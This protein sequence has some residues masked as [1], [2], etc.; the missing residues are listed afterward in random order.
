MEFTR[1]NILTDTPGGKSMSSGGIILEGNQGGSGGDYVHP[2]G[3]LW[4]NK[5]T[6]RETLDGD[7]TSHGTIKCVD[8]NA[9]NISSI[10]LTS[11]NINAT[12][13][14]SVNGDFTD[15]NVFDNLTSYGADIDHATIRN[16]F[17]SGSAHF[18]ELI[19]DKLNSTNGSLILSPAH[20]EISKVEVDGN[21]ITCYFLASDGEKKI[22]NDFDV[23]D[24]VI[25][26]SFN[27]V[28][29]V[30]HDVDNKFIWKRCIA[31][32]TTQDGSEHWIK[33]YTTES[34]MGAN[35][36]HTDC[37][38]E[39]EVADVICTLGNWIKTDRQKAI[40]MTA[41]NS[42]WLD[43]GN[44]TADYNHSYEVTTY[45]SNNP[46]IRTAN[47][48]LAIDVG[49]L[50]NGHYV[51]PDNI[52]KPYVLSFID[53]E[54]IGWGQAFGNDGY[55]SNDP[56]CD[57]KIFNINQGATVEFK[58]RPHFDESIH[59]FDYEYRDNI[60]RYT[61]LPTYHWG[62]IDDGDT[63]GFSVFAMMGFMVWCVRTFK[64]VIEN[65]NRVGYYCTYK[66][67][68]CKGFDIVREIRLSNNTINS[69]YI[70]ESDNNASSDSLLNYLGGR[71]FKPA[72]SVRY[73]VYAGD[74]FGEPGGPAGIRCNALA[75]LSANPFI[76][77]SPDYTQAL[78]NFVIDLYSI[79]VKQNGLVLWDYNAN[80][81]LGEDMIVNG[82]FSKSGYWETTFDNDTNSPM[83]LGNAAEN[84]YM[85]SPY[86]KSIYDSSVVYGGNNSLKDKYLNSN[87][88]HFDDGI[89]IL[90]FDYYINNDNNISYYNENRSFNKSREKFHFQLSLCRSDFTQSHVRSDLEVYP[91]VSGLHK[92]KLIIGINVDTTGMSLPDNF[93]NINI[94]SGV[95]RDYLVGINTDNIGN[96]NELVID[97]VHLRKVNNST[98]GYVKHVDTWECYPGSYDLFIYTYPFL[99][100]YPYPFSC[101]QLVEKKYKGI[102]TNPIDAPAII[103]FDNINDFSL[104]G[105]HISVLSPRYNLISANSVNGLDDRISHSSSFQLLEDQINMTVTQ[106]E[107]DELNQTVINQGT[108]ISQ[109]A[110]AITLKADKTTVNT[111]SGEVSS[112]NSSIT[113]LSD[114][115]TLNSSAIT[116]LNSD[117]TQLSSEL[118]I[119]AGEISSLVSSVSS[120]DGEV[121]RLWSSITQLPDQISAYVYTE[122]DGDLTQTGIDITNHQISLT[123]DNFIVKNNNNNPTLYLNSQGLVE[124]R[125]G[126]VTNPRTGSEETF[127]PTFY[128]LSMERQNNDPLAYSIG[129]SG[130]NKAYQG[131]PVINQNTDYTDSA[132]CDFFKVST[133]IYNKTSDLQYR[134]PILTMQ[135]DDF[136]LYD[137]NMNYI[138]E[139]L[140]S[141]R[142][143][144]KLQPKELSF[145]WNEGGTPQL[146]LVKDLDG[147]MVPGIESWVG[148]V[149]KCVSVGVGHSLLKDASVEIIT[150]W[151][152]TIDD[153]INGH[154]LEWSAISVGELIRV[155]KTSGDKYSTLIIKELN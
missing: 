79:T 143:T 92:F 32:G 53:D 29:G 73:L 11:V 13:L 52:D 37:N 9:T 48:G 46:Y 107:F 18:V 20:A 93:I 17:V 102:V 8:L 116:S 129:L 145:S 21:Y 58:F 83:E 68:L 66:F 140:V 2:T 4:G 43:I 126:F 118:N 146:G 147:N 34:N 88:F 103:T 80:L 85:I 70:T 124:S 139:G 97:N 35:Y 109:N 27:A 15:L 78:N 123:A 60:T 84:A 153:W 135:Q 136:T 98:D 99:G 120:I 131:S 104:A 144:M 12:N 141:C 42:K 33:F 117:Y 76:D 41:T 125:L 149:S 62:V 74:I 111:L 44:V 10:N 105:R 122:L 1:T 114:R 119:Q 154:S 155:K 95:S 16:L 56:K 72:T 7:L 38:S 132:L 91:N 121:T 87:V 133:D 127:N 3:W 90:E 89:Y 5:Y 128:A 94:V 61:S 100:T 39:F 50:D 86:C 115:I 30:S 67:Y 65:G 110:S 45:D 54:T 55:F 28:E 108:L 14:T 19:I 77:V 142:T 36:M 75:L 31:K 23:D 112:L 113:V 49:V 57:V 69:I 148:G 25:C 150:G 47:P 63:D 82:D 152:T 101:D 134:I 96:E 130:F 51:H 40:L 151:N 138:D 59:Y 81:S 106:S 22:S 26:Q 137:A 64:Y 24:L 71:Y 6:G